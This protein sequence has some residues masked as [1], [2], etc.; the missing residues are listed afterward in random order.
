MPRFGRVESYMNDPDAVAHEA[1][2]WL[3]SLPSG[4]EQQAGTVY[5]AVAEEFERR[6]ISVPE[7]G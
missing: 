5:D 1:R 7:G 2:R 3:R 4:A 6:G